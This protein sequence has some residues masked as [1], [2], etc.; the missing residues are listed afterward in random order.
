MG[1]M[2]FH[3]AR[4]L[5]FGGGGSF[6]D[7]NMPSSGSRKAGLKSIFKPRV[8]ASVWKLALESNQAKPRELVPGGNWPAAG[9]RKKE[10]Y[11]S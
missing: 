9:A 6:L 10:R 1:S 11:F 8:E 5:N 2:G 3:E 7:E 4:A